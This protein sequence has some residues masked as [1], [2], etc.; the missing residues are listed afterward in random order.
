MGTFFTATS[1]NASRIVNQALLILPT[2][3]II[4]HPEMGAAAEGCVESVDHKLTA[5]WTI[6]EHFFW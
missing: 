5:F 2:P 3:K 6:L 4:A 1:H